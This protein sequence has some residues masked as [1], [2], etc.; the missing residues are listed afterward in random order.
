MVE[1]VEGE[2]VGSAGVVVVVGSEGVVVVEEVGLVGG[3][4]G[5]EVGL[6][7]VEEEDLAAEEEV[8]DSVA[9]EEEKEEVPVT[10]EKEKV[11]VTEE[12]EEEEVVGMVDDQSPDSAQEAVVS[13]MGKGKE[14]LIAGM[15]ER[16]R[17]SHHGV[18]EDGVIRGVLIEDEG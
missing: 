18:G 16:T 13:E 6:A 1:A 2:G 14:D 9:A 7:V 10:E 17:M 4:Q 5:V 12:K 3:V 11:P 8:V 15:G